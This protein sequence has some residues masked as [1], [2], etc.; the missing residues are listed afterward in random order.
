MGNAGRP[1]RWPLMPPVLAVFLV[2]LAF[3][4]LVELGE[5]MR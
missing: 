1:G 5:R 2:V 4:A 3:A